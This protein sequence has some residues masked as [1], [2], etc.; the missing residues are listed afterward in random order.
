MEK[1]ESPTIELAG[2]VGNEEPNGLFIPLVAAIFAA[3]AMYVL[4]VDIVVIY[5][6]VLT[7]SRNII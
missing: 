6:T 4:L 2:G 5:D 1:Y 3:G 7:P